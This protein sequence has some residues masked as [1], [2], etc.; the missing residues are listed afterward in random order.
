MIDS[1]I[2]HYGPHNVARIAS[3][4]NE[5]V[6]SGM[7]HSYNLSNKYGGYGDRSKLS[8]DRPGGVELNPHKGIAGL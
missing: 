3:S 7:G 4:P 5:A 8:N 2:S 1:P 6:D